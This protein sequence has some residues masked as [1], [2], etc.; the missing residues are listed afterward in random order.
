MDL[1]SKRLRQAHTALKWYRRVSY[2]R[3]EV[4]RAKT[5]TLQFVEHAKVGRTIVSK[6]VTLVQ[7]GA[8]E[9]DREYIRDT[10]TEAAKSRAKQK[11]WA[12]LMRT[13]IFPESK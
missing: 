8:T 4:H 7:D 9:E 2:V 3:G 10:I 5:E 6:S 1:L 11:L 13:P 12:H